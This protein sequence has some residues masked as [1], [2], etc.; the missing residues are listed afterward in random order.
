MSA[1]AAIRYVDRATG[2]ERSE[3]VFGETGL[4][5]LY[6]NALGRVLAHHVVSH[7]IV[8]ALY[9]HK[10]ARDRD[11]RGFVDAYDVDAAAAEFGVDAYRNVASFFERRL[12][13]GARPID[14]TAHHMV[15]PVDGRVLAIDC[16]SAHA[17]PVKGHA[18][19][20]RALV[21]GAVAADVVDALDAALVFRLA[22]AD[23]HRVHLPCGGGLSAPVWRGARLHSVHP[24]ALAGGAP[25]F[26]NKRS[27]SVLTSPVFG[28]VIVVLVGAM[29]VGTI[30]H[31][32]GPGPCVKGDELGLFSFG[33]STVVLLCDRKKVAVDDDLWATSARGLETLVRMGT[34]VAASPTPRAV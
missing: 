21:A 17:L 31:T 10:K 3:R 8:S 1:P 15:S 29:L 9:A 5:R 23:Y 19:D 20:K 33:G 7:P 4:R 16:A 26:G 25:S 30:T 6:G 12:R 34:R 22:P 11:V 28:T 13:D 24:I 2:E 18:L 32:H 14:A 27:V